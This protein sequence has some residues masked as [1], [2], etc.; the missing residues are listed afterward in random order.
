M[1]RD[2]LFK[3]ESRHSGKKR[4]ARRQHKDEPPVDHSDKRPTPIKLANGFQV[5]GRVSGIPFE[6]GKKYPYQIDDDEEGDANDMLDGNQVSDPRNRHHA[7]QGAQPSFPGQR[8]VKHNIQ[9]SPVALLCLQ[10]L[11]SVQ[12]QS[13]A[14]ELMA[15][16][17]DRKQ[18]PPEKGIAV[19]SHMVGRRCFQL[20]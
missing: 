13:P 1:I 5:V 6:R 8:G 18:A 11:S 14:V 15:K 4:V 12:I 3:G 16:T 10:L 2:H 9:G 19:A 7:I 20:H 17:V